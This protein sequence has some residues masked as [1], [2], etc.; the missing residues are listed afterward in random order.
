M[1][2]QVIASVL[3]SAA[4]ANLVFAQNVCPTTGKPDCPSTLSFTDKISV[5]ET[6]SIVN[7]KG[8][9]QPTLIQFLQG[10]N[11]NLSDSLDIS[12]TIPVYIE[13]TTELGAIGLDLTWDAFASEKLDL[14]LRVGLDTPMNTVYGASSFDPSLGGAVTVVLP[15]NSKFIQTVNYEFVTGDA[16][17]LA[18]GS[19]VTEDIL[20]MNS[21]WV[22]SLSKNLDLGL[23][24]WQNYTVDSDGQQNIL[25]GP[26]LKWSITDNISLDTSI[27][28]PVY[29]NV[30]ASAEQN[31]TL[32][33]SLGI[34]F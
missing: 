12:L 24:V 8:D 34:K 7:Y 32:T 6:F 25:V 21:S 5:T 18:F 23:N 19:K 15:W 33:A 10:V 11:Y 30:T 20:T 31:Y 2:K 1:F 26:D 29:Q 9:V 16:F 3:V 22:H 14:A 4:A 17:S 13:E 28:L 27:A